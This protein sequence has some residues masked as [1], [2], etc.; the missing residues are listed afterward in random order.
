MTKYF[1]WKIFLNETPKDDI[2]M[3]LV[4]MDIRGIKILILDLDQKSTEAVEGQD[5]VYG[6]KKIE[7]YRPG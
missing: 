7:L 4:P 1:T 5:P 6:I 2:E 3:V